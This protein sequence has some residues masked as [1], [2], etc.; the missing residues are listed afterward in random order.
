MNK[1]EIKNLMI[2]SGY[3]IKSFFIDDIPLYE[4][5]NEYLSEKS[6][7]LQSISPV[8]ELAICWTDDYDCEGD[9]EFMKFI[10]SET[11]FGKEN[12]LTFVHSVKIIKMILVIH[13]KLFMLH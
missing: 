7:L 4:Y 2:P 8:C 1:L 9:A 13:P 12:F 5:I 11:D 10:L 6:A 3:E